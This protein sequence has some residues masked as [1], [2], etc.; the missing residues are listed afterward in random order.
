MRGGTLPF[1]N[2]VCVCVC[3][4]GGGWV[5]RGCEEGLSPSQR[6]CVCVSVCVCASVC[7]CRLTYLGRLKK[8]LG[9]PVT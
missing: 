4:G 9:R 6:V 5:G 2:G 8:P 7:V 3:V 1:L